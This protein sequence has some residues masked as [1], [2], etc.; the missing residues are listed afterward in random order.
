MEP[1]PLVLVVRVDEEIGSR[2]CKAVDQQSS[3]ACQRI[4]MVPLD[5]ATLSK[6]VV[7]KVVLEKP[8]RNHRPIEL[9]RRKRGI[10]VVGVKGKGHH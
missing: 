4:Q 7:H 10:E 3:A 9:Q 2:V 6:H 8:G 1:L 5:V